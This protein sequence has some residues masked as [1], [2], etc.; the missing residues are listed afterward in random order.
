MDI[1][2]NMTFDEG[3]DLFLDQVRKEHSYTG[4]L[5]KSSFRDDYAVDHKTPEAAAEDFVLDLPEED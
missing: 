4:P 2:D 1:T 3:Y 5:D